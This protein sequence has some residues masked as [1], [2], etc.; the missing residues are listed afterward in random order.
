MFPVVEDGLLSLG[1]LGV[2]PVLVRQCPWERIPLVQSHPPVPMAPLNGLPTPLVRMMG[3]PEDWDD[4]PTGSGWYSYDYDSR[5]MS[6][7]SSENCVTR[8]PEPAIV[9]S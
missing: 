4:T 5:G 2:L 1:Q 6:V 8:S 9:S 7:R 3:R